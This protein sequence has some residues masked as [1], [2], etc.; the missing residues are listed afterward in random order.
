MVHEFR[1]V[2]GKSEPQ[3]ILFS[4]AEDIE[5]LAI[6]VRKSDQDRPV[7]VAEFGFTVPKMGS[8]TDIFGKYTAL[9]DCSVALEPGDIMLI[10]RSL[11]PPSYKFLVRGIWTKEGVEIEMSLAE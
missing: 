1:F 9:T 2:Q 7:I 5:Y 11:P 8:L 6:L 3:S 10:E 4:Y